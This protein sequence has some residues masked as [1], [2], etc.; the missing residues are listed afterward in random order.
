MTVGK[1]RDI[2]TYEQEEWL[3]A[4]RKGVGGSDA[5]VILGLSPYK[6]WMTLFVEKTDQGLDPQ[7]P[8]EAAYWGQRL[9]ELVAR[10]FEAR[11]QLRVG[12]PPQRLY[13]HRVCSWMVGTPDRFVYDPITGEF[14]GILE[15]KTANERRAKEWED[16]PAPFAV[17]Q[18]QHYMEVVD[19]PRGWIAVLLGGQRYIHFPIER[20]PVF[21]ADLMEKEAAFW[22][23]VELNDPPPPDGR[24]STS[25]IINSRFA[26]SVE[27]SSVE[28]EG[29]ALAK[30][31]ELVNLTEQVLPAEIDRLR[32][33]LKL[34]L[35][36][37]EI[38][39]V[40][41]RPVISWRPQTRTVTD[42]TRL[43]RDHGDLVERYAKTTTFRVFRTHDRNAPAGLIGEDE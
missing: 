38:G 23:H 25:H 26:Q 6:G 11:A 2:S 12:E 32:N 27:D 15:I 41:G 9:E 8:S 10:E 21:I 30:Y 1:L 16:G 34:V 17:A 3:A 18:L 24:E 31:H 4:R 35:G 5:P 20:D 22:R 28:L 19:A 14:L 7:E 42:M 37:K 13:V 33:E 36:E 40:D 29:D 39:L 43:K